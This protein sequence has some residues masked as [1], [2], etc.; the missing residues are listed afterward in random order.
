[1]K[2]E[3][4]NRLEGRPHPK[5]V[6]F[7]GRDLHVGDRVRVWPK[8]GSDN[9]DFVMAGKIAIIED[10]EQDSENKVHLAVV[11]DREHG[12]DSEVTHPPGHRFFYHLEEVEP[13]DP[14]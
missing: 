3:D 8:N 9:K 5:C 10:I 14:S 7:C 13:L 2:E 12:R 1:M 6:S 4:W 11:V